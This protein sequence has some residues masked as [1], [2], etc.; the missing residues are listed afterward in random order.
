MR[1]LRNGATLCLALG[2]A[3]SG[4]RKDVPPTIE[5]CVLDGFGGGDCIE[6]DG[7]KKYR[8]PSEMTNY[9][10][11]SSEDLKE[12]AS[13]CYKTKPELVDVALKSI[14]EKAKAK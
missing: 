8:A 3:L 9:W 11:T 7:S 6:R 14:L 2:L 1:R 10:S 12:W 13:W 4:C 5:N